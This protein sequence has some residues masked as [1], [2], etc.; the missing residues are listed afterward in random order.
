M[1]MHKICFTE[2]I[3]G[4]FNI[5][6]TSPHIPTFNG[7]KKNVTNEKVLQLNISAYY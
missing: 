5:T 2:I 1:E 7:R 6:S 4:E 3:K